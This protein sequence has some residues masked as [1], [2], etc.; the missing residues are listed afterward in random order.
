MNFFK[1]HFS[2]RTC[3]ATILRTKAD[4]WRAGGLRFVLCGVRYDD[5]MTFFVKT[6]KTRAKK[7]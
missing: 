5:V 1:S 6:V 2:A 3:G 7:D 4:V